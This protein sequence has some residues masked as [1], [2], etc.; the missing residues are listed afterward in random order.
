MKRGIITGI[1]GWLIF[2]L[3]SCEEPV[4]LTVPIP[5]PRL[6][7]ISNFTLDRDLQVR[8]SSSQPS[9][10]LGTGNAVLEAAVRLYAGDD[11]VQQLILVDSVS[12]PYY[13]TRNFSPEPGIAYTLTVSAPGFEPVYGQSLVP[14]GVP[15]HQ[16]LLQNLHRSRDSVSQ[17]QQYQYD[18]SLF[19]S[20]PVDQQNFYHLHLYQEFI[21]FRLVGTDTLNTGRV[22]RRI[23]F[24]EQ[25]TNNLQVVHYDG[26]VLFEDTPFNGSDQVL[27]LPIVI[28][29]DESREYPGRLIAELR[30]VTEDYYLFHTSLSRQQQSP[31]QPFA[32]PVLL[33]NNI[34][35]GHGVFAGYSSSTTSVSVR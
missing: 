13:T 1:L 12:E 8:V 7:V 16:I 15:I 22:L 23:R 14:P 33:Y 17:R 31:D 5:D 19:F 18:L 29:F 21:T 11:L 20:D 30:A 34:R 10:D 27:S 6:V 25:N 24:D 35:N 3:W 32:D 28:R 2:G 26:S 9:V 4:D